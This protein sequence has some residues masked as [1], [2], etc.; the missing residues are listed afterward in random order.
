MVTL[1][2]H[3]KSIEALCRKYNIEIDILNLDRWDDTLTKE[4]NLSVI[5]EEIKK[6]STQDKIIENNNYDKEYTEH[7]QS[8]SVKKELE[9]I[10]E[11]EKEALEQIRK[12]TTPNLDVHYNDMCEYVKMVSRGFVNS[13]FL[14]GSGGIGKTFN[15]IRTLTTEKTDFKYITGNITPLIMYKLL[16]DNK[17][18][19]IIFDDTHGLLNNPASMS[20]LFSAMW[21]PTGKRFVEW[22]TSSKLIKGIPDRFEFQGRIIFILN[23]IPDTE[24]MKILVSRCLHFNLEFGRPEILKI[25]YEITK[26]PHPELKIK[27]RM[28]VVDFIRKVTN[29]ATSDFNLRL[30]KKIEQIYL[31]DKNNWKRLSSYLVNADEDLLIVDELMNGDYTLREQLNLFFEK[32]G[33]SRASFYRLRSK[34]LP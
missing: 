17:N 2:S 7:L 27:E 22:H 1:I 29:S 19:T 12:S 18:R 13:L 24:K 10:A 26:I 21:A 34:L 30:Q 3:R 4:E 28:G 32:T 20:T 6:L 15:A 25:M 8:E 9:H 16:Y 11:Q 23:E 5:E 31:Y 14:V 33:K